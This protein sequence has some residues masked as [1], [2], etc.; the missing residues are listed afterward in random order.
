MCDV[1]YILH[2]HICTYN[3]IIHVLMR[4]EEEGK[5]QARSNEQQ[6]RATQHTQGSQFS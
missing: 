2:K 1:T 5:T 4:D 6:G 3:I